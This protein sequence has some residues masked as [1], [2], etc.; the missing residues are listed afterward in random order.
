M[1]MSIPESFVA[2]AAPATEA[3]LGLAQIQLDAFEQFS[4][5]T[6]NAGREALQDGVAHTRRLLNARDMQELIRL[7]AAAAQP[8]LE[9]ALDYSRGVC[10]IATHSQAEIARTLETQ[11]GALSRSAA[12]FLESMSQNAPAGSDVV[13][14]AMK[15]AIVATGNAVE[16]LSR[17]SRQASGIAE[18]NLNAAVE[19]AK[20]NGKKAA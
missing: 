16:N 2:P 12:S 1:P 18:A 3:L 20:S 9:K 4:T 11:A 10:G 15:S 13:V 17:M 6:I 5:L 8:S 7:N 19:H 14:A